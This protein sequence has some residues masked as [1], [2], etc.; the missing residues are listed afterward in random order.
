MSACQTQAAF[1]VIPERMNCSCALSAL[2]LFA[3]IS[4]EKSLD[5]FVLGN[6]LRV[7][8]CWT[9]R[10]SLQSMR[11]SPAVWSGAVESRF[12]PGRPEQEL[13]IGRRNS[14]CSTAFL[15]QMT[16]LA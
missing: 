15:P 3:W 16:A 11:S 12:H 10:T 6:Y 2:G 4:R 7:R 8:N 14:R 5:E 13:D 9:T 1:A